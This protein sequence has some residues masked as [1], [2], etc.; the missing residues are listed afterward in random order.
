M[1][2]LGAFRLYGQGFISVREWP[3][4]PGNSTGLTTPG[5]KIVPVFEFLNLGTEKHVILKMKVDMGMARGGNAAPFSFSFTHMG[6]VY[7]DRDLG[8]D[9]FT[10][11]RLN[12]ATFSVL[13]Q[14]ANNMSRQIK[15]VSGIGHFDLGI[16]SQSAL[17][18]EYAA[19]VQS[20]DNI[21]Y[22]GTENI[23]R[24][25]NL[26]EDERKKKIMAQNQPESKP[27]NDLVKTSIP[28]PPATTTKPG[29]NNQPQK[30]TANIV[31]DDFWSGKKD[32]TP[33]TTGTDDKVIPDQPNH[34][35]LP[36]FIRTT[37]GGYYHRGEDGKIREVTAEEY[38]KAKAAVTAKNTV[39]V[40]EEQKMTAAEVKS[41]VDK[42]FSDARARDEAVTARINQFSQAM[43]QNYYY[44]EAIRNGKQ[45][46]A[47][48]SSLSGN[49]SSIAELEAEFN[50]KYS[51]IRGEVQNLE[52]ARNAKLGNAA[53]ANFNGSSTEQAIGQGIKLIGGIFNS[54]K[55]S[56]EEKEAKEALRA[57]RERQAAALKAAKIKARNELRS[58]LIK[59]FP[60]GGTPLTAHKINLPAVYM[61]GY[62]TDPLTINN[63]AADV[64][65]SNVFPVNQYSDGSY[66]L[67]TVVAG[68]LKGVGRGDVVLVGFYG[69]RNAAEQMRKSFINLAQ[70]SDLAVRTITLKTAGA[71]TTTAGNGSTDFWENGQKTKNATDT[72][73]K[74][75]NFWNN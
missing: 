70:K 10:S 41:A 75:D 20:L 33:E 68:R 38:Q 63:E 51:S 5:F 57:E 55:A 23:I 62:I 36:D 69:D 65:V 8:F 7:T 29:I 25:I 61:F 15:Y 42:M 34:K 60:N 3:M 46:L 27:E 28:S 6:R 43:Q 18:S 72:T 56:R 11:I 39:P 19:H 35:N 24:A 4:P 74:K 47:E 66:P 73:K 13:V 17:L 14:G 53:D 52:Q 44:S 22:N 21:D 58:Q 9:P 49:F 67:K 48:L 71:G 30:S 64:L 26:F 37:D 45:N 16:V 54:A 32:K 12:T 59:S 31:K 1:I 50:Q 2:L 40:A